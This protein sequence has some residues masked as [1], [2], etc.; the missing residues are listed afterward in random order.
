[1]SLNYPLSDRLQHS[2]NNQQINV[3]YE[4][5][6]DNKN[7]KRIKKEYSSIMEH[8]GKFCFQRVFIYGDIT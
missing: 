1:M 4:L 5:C 3:S 7:K 6:V 2:N 8:Q